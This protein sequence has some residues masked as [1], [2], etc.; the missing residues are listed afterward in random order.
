MRALVLAALV[1]A[2]TAAFTADEPLS[3]ADPVLEQRYQHLLEE[4]RCLVCQNQSL[5]D[6]HAELAQDLRNEVYRMLDDGADDAGI[7]DFMVE[8]YGDF[9]LYRPP[10]KRSTWVLWAGPA[11][12]VLIAGVVLVRIASRRGEAPRALDDE[13]RARLESLLEQRRSDS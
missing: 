4:L 6:S 2:A 9:V 7:L 5:A 10:L 11:V 12:M 1:G 3:F 13:E 8:R